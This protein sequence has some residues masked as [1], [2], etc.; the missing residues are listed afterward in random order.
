MSCC[1][2]TDTSQKFKN[3]R[4]IGPG[5]IGWAFNG[6]NKERYNNYY[7]CNDNN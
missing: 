4:N 5:N 7:M 6:P 2:D 1:L 3:P